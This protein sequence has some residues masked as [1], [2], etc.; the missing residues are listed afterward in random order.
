VFN[1][2][3]ALQLGGE[4]LS[5]T[6]VQDLIDLA[7]S[8]GKGMVGGSDAHARER[9]FVCWTEIGSTAEAGAPSHPPAKLP[10]LIRAIRNGHTTPGTSIPAY[11]PYVGKNGN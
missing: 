5:K 11:M 8:S 3:M 2:N 1:G 10:D 9:F 7:K 6:Y 4:M